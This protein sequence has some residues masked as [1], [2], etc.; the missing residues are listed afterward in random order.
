MR[1]LSGV[2]RST[3]E[4]YPSLKHLSLLFDSLCI[5]GLEERKA[6]IRNNLS[7]RAELDFL[8]SRKFLVDAEF[9]NPQGAVGDALHFVSTFME[10]HGPMP[11]QF[12]LTDVIRYFT[13]RSVVARLQRQGV[14]SVGLFEDETAFSKYVGQTGTN[15][16]PMTD[17]LTVGLNALPVPHEDCPWEDIL[18]FK[19]E[20]QEK[21]WGFRRFLR[22]LATQRKTEAEIRDELD[23]MVKEYKN[24][25]RLHHIKASHSFVDVFVISP[26]EI[27]ENLMKFNWSKIA[28]GALQVQKRKVELIEAEMK[29][30]GRECAYVFDARKRF[31]P[32]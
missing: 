13:V 11:E 6:W 29:A 4:L 32:K 8:E 27:I 14:N 5:I 25:M 31:A 23:W 15:A 16:P 3:E 30:P 12:P 7:F 9:G 18:D 1:E 10:T 26:L 20:L 21:E 22:T 19:E 2:V 24:A 17:V 28:K